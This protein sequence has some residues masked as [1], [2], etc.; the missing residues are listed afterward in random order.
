MGFPSFLLLYHGWAVGGDTE[1]TGPEAGDV[2]QRCLGTSETTAASSSWEFGPT[3][4]QSLRTQTLLKGFSAV[5]NECEPG[6][7]EAYWSQCYGGLLVRSTWEAGTRTVLET[8]I[9]NQSWHNSET[10]FQSQTPQYQTHS[11]S[12]SRRKSQ[13]TILGQSHHRVP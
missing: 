4:Q 12:Q 3:D 6:S 13:H 5:E 11:K 2:L 1:L 8:H 7:A 9:Q 10:S